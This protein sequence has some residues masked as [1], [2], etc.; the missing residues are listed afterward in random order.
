MDKTK[1]LWESWTAWIATG[2]LTAMVT[3]YK[4]LAPELL[5]PMSLVLVSLILARGMADFG[6]HQCRCLRPAPLPP[7]PPPVSAKP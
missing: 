7:E 5:W 1:P 6:K 3:F 4:D 2:G